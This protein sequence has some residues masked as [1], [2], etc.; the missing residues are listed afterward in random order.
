MWCH[1][2][3]LYAAN[4]VVVV[5]LPPYSLPPL[6]AVMDIGEDMPQKHSKEEGNVVEMGSNC[7]AVNCCYCFVSNCR[8]CSYR[9]AAGWAAGRGA[10]SRVRSKRFS[11]TVGDVRA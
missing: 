2:L 1:L 7:P 4:H 9:P 11:A 8:I 10:S 5:M 6:L 3:R